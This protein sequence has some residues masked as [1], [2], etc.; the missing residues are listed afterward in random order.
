M[1][2][3]KIKIYIE[4]TQKNFLELDDILSILCDIFAQIQD[5]GLNNSKWFL[6]QR[7]FVDTLLAYYDKHKDENKDI[8]IVFQPLLHC[9]HKEKQE[10]LIKKILDKDLKYL[11]KLDKILDDMIQNFIIDETKE[12]DKNFLLDV[13]KQRLDYNL[14]DDFIIE[15]LE[16]S[17]IVTFID[18][19]K[20]EIGKAKK[21]LRKLSKLL[22]KTYNY[23]F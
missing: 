20:I 15:F 12:P 6:L 23:M 8:A 1:K 7:D 21:I 4:Q 22:V 11:S 14:K 17:D 3:R 10:P 2:T 13:I 19:E 16:A 9:I 5:F 18:N